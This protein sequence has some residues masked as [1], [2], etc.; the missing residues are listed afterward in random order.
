MT[1]FEQIGVEFQLEAMT[2]NQANK[3]LRY[4][5]KVCCSRGMRIDCDRCAIAATNAMV[6]ASFNLPANVNRKVLETK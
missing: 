4:S 6:V 5:C 2:P 1:K 3:A